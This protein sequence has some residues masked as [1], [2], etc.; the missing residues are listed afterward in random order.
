MIEENKRF[1]YYCSDINE[2]SLESFWM[3]I[4]KN[5]LFYILF[6]KLQANEYQNVKVT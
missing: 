4:F 2:L 5:G 6:L 1:L 3:R